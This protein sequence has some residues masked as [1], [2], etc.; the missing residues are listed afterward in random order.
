MEAASEASRT[1]SRAVKTLFGLDHSS[2]SVAT[3]E[4]SLQ[5]EDYRPR[6]RGDADGASSRRSAASWS[7]RK[8]VDA[9]PASGP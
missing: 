2:P 6:S 8:T 1:P 9:L 7:D 5:Y 4:A 3:V